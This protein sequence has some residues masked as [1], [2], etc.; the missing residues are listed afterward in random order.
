MVAVQTSYFATF[1]PFVNQ[2]SNATSEPWAVILND[3]KLLVKA[4]GTWDG[5]SIIVQNML[6]QSSPAIWINLNTTNGQAFSFTANSEYT[7][8]DLVSNEQIRFV[9]SGAGGS[10]NLTV[11]C[12]FI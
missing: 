2:T 8:E 10:T 9:L 5:A 3:R 6:P 7:V 4:G 12:E 11:S 1:F